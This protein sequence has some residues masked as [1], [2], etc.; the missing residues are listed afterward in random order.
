MVKAIA[1]LS[2]MFFLME[3]IAL[4]LAPFL[5]RPIQ[6][7]ETLE[8]ATQRLTGSYRV[9]DARF[10]VVDPATSRIVAKAHYDLV[11]PGWLACVVDQQ[12]PT[13][14]MPG[15]RRSGAATVARTA[16]G[17]GVGFLVP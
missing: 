6:P 11:R 1:A 12:P 14:S 3:G 17:A 8:Q 13:S 9:Y 5:C 7:G 2:V 4:A 16:W 10:Q 15:V